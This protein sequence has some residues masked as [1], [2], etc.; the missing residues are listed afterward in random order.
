MLAILTLVAAIGASPKP[1][2]LKSFDDWSI[3]CDNG[4]ACMAVSLMEMESGENQL[5]LQ[6][7]RA[8]GGDAPAQLRIPNIEED[9]A[10]APVTL[11][12]E[13]GAV[14]LRTA[15]PEPGASLTLTADP[16]FLSALRTGRRVQLR[17]TD[18]QVLGSASLRGLS[19]ALA[20]MEAQ[21][22]AVT[23]PPALP[24]ISVPRPPRP[25]T[26]AL[27]ATDVQSL[28]ARIGCDA[29]DAPLPTEAV[30]L[31]SRN[32]LAL[33]ACNSSPYN[34]VTAPV[35]ISGKGKS[36]KM[37]PAE[38]DFGAGLSPI[39]GVPLVSNANWDP[40]QGELSSFTKGRGLGDCGSA[41]TYV[42]DGRRFRLT[43]QFA[44]AECRGV[45]DWI[46]TWRAN[47]VRR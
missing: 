5:T 46:P 33:V 41:E 38:F 17:T 21:Q 3:G 9:V 26:M 15:L 12:L 2:E 42:W 24:T 8:P 35:L 16:S 25:A 47:V 40:L 29:G 6:I 22:G 18:N 1:G 28:Q 7:S 34:F 39:E 23:R 37:K 27:S 30:K 20:Y 14:V 31:D 4:R 19:D 13:T 36:R 43:A 45:L 44:M 32:W 10:G 11:A